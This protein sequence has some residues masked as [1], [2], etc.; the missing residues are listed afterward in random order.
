MLACHC[1]AT[2]VYPFNPG[3]ITWSEMC[4]GTPVV[5][6]CPF[7]NVAGGCVLIAHSQE[8]SAGQS[9]TRPLRKRLQKPQGRGCNLP[10]YQTRVTPCGAPAAVTAE[11]TERT[12]LAQRLG[13]SAHS[14]PAWKQAAFTLCGAL[15]ADATRRTRVLV[16]ALTVHTQP[17]SSGGATFTPPGGCACRRR[18]R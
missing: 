4:S 6:A 1:T 10:Y 8:G 16:V 11:C 17:A 3:F 12:A 13:S 14:Q 18:R 2:H 15:A 7:W 5:R 9:A